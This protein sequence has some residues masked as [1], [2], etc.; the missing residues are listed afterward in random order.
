M[1]IPI[2]AGVILLFVS[3]CLSYPV[4][5]ESPHD[6]A[7]NHFSFFYWL[8]LAILF[9]S[10]FVVGVEA[11]SNTLRWA[12]TVGTVLLVFSQAY[13]SY[14]VPGADA[15]QVRGLTEYFISTGDLDSSQINHE[16]FQWPSYFVLCKIA[17]LVPGLD[18]RLL[19]FVLYGLMSLI[20][21][22]FLYLHI[23]R[24]RANAYI[25]VMAFFI[26]LSYFFNFQWA[27]PFSLSLC[28]LF[29]LFHFDGLSGKRE[30][31]L[32]MLLVLACLT[33]VHVFTPILFI[34]YCFGMYVVRR[35]IKYLRFTA[36]NGIIYALTMS[37]SLQFASYVKML[38]N[39]AFFYIGNRLQ[40]TVTNPLT[41]QPYIDVVAQFFSR[42]VVIVTAL[43]TAL[44]L[45]I[46]LRGRKLPTTDYVMLIAGA[47]FSL[48]VLVA[49]SNYA[50][51]SGRT[52]FL[53]CLPASLGAAYLC[54]SKFKKYFKL[55]FLILLVLFTFALMHQSF[56]ERQIVFQT[57]Q[58]YQCSDFMLDTVDWNGSGYV[59]S[60]FR[61]MMYLKSASYSAT[62]R[63]SADLFYSEDFSGDMVKYNYVVYTV[64]LSKSLLA[65]NYSTE[66]TS[67]ELED[68]H[69]NLIYN[70]G[71]LSCIFSK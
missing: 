2:V 51:L 32:A 34:G 22:S 6:F 26:I 19:E 71:N 48:T 53:F 14:M 4:S 5:I 27:S 63:Y 58:E 12:V 13:F 33:F 7:F 57:E 15:P 46:L 62:V 28:L 43:L 35:D 24:V 18:L 69:Y 66:A 1:L 23:S 38:A 8:S 44:G 11:K 60:H 42:T 47:V 36:V 41:L 67:K 20:V 37:H 40:A 55:T 30:V 39:L 29:V 70:S 54:E 3:W 65:Y 49:P 21:T 45:V 9:A 61:F 68:S 56:Y 10:F 64:G 16:Y 52:L 31:I 17:S 25:A 59:F 50:E